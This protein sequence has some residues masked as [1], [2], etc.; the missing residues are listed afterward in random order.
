MIE[1]SIIEGD[2]M[3]KIVLAAGIICLLF[4]AVLTSC[5][6]SS[7]D[8]GGSDGSKATLLGDSLNLSGTVD[9]TFDTA[10]FELT[11]TYENTNS[12]SFRLYDETDNTTY[13]TDDNTGEKVDVNLSYSG[14]PT[15]HL[16]DPAPYGYTSSNA[17]AQIT[18]AV[19]DVVGKSDDIVFGDLSA[20]PGVWYYYLYSTA[21]TT[22]SGSY[23]DS[24]ETHAFDKVTVF[25][26][27]NQLIVSTSD[28]TTFTYRGGVIP[29]GHWTYMDNTEPE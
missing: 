18:T 11:S 2:N 9:R 19:I 12:D 29:D 17:S 22:L 16:Y 15:G 25:K 6:S 28:G 3:K 8:G 1:E 21:E 26:G 27:W 7:S 14:E 20:V 10:T 23:T 5:D 24:G 13:A 4:F